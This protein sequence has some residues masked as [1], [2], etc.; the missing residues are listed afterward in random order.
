MANPTGV[1]TSN[2]DTKSVQIDTTL[3]DKEYYFV[4][5]DTTDDNVVNLAA[6]ALLQPY[7]LL[8]GKAGTSTDIKTG[9]IATNG[10][11]KLL[12]A[13]T[14]TA[15]VQLMSDANGKGVAATDGKV[16]GAIALENG[17][18]GDYISVQVQQGVYKTV[19]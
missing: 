8:E 9:L 17:V 14:I 18:S 19:S 16:Y 15:G 7:V 10:Q 12:I 3:T 11:T 5:F 4:T 1:I 6:A 2:V 13:A